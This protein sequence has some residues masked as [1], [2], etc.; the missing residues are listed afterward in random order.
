MQLESKSVLIVEMDI[1]GMELL[2]WKN[3]PKVKFLIWWQINANA[4]LDFSGMMKDVLVVQVEEF[5]IPIERNVNA[6]KG[7]DGMVSDVLQFKFVK[8]EKYGTFLNLC[9]NVLSRVIGMEHIV[10]ELYHVQMAK[11]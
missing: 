2:A 10:S 3:V 1:F 9:A 8:M 7:Q 6:Q 5:L 11:F 4:Q